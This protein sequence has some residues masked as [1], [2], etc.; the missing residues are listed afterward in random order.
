MEIEDQEIITAD[1]ETKPLPIEE[2][3]EN[4]LEEETE[5]GTPVIAEGLSEK[6][7]E[8]L[9]TEE[10]EKN[11]SELWE[12]STAKVEDKKAGAS[13]VEKDGKYGH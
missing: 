3:L 10:K 4:V 12:G 8:H 13:R 5:K 11:K 2:H 7:R 1:V 9:S 6:S